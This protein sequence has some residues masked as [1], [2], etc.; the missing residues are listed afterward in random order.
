MTS[1]SN[2][3]R[4]SILVSRC[5]I[6]CCVLEYSAKS[7]ANLV[8][9]V[10][11][12][13]SAGEMERENTALLV[14]GLRLLL[15]VILTRCQCTGFRCVHFALGLMTEIVILLFLEI[16]FFSI[17]LV[18]LIKRQEAEAEVAELGC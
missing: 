5:L 17:C 15:A 8:F 18:T 12:E 10:S 13:V 14:W 6:F 7:R 1:E 2:S 16:I 9:S 11:M 4:R 3:S